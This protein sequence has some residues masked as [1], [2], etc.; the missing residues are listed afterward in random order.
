MLKMAMVAVIFLSMLASAMSHG[1]EQC[2]RETKTDYETLHKEFHTF[3]TSKRNV[4]I[5]KFFA[6][7]WKRQGLMDA[8][9]SVIVDKFPEYFATLVSRY[10]NLP[11][12]EQRKAEIN[13]LIENGLFDLNFEGD[14][15]R[16][17]IQLVNNI[18]YGF[19]GI[20]F[21]DREPGRDLLEI[22]ME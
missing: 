8:D 14:Q 15:E 9:G 20:T 21:A 19:F 3:Q 11:I 16:D 12:T 2:L 1:Q 13:R 17:A 6:C 10:R 4:I 22:I 7:L 18:K 5:G